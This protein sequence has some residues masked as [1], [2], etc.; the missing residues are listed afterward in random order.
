MMAKRLGIDFFGGTPFLTGLGG[1]LISPGK[2]F[3][4]YSPVAILFFFSIRSFLKKHP[5]PGA[6][7]ICIILS[8]VLFLSKNIYWHGDWAWGPRYMLVITPFLIIPTAH[9][10]DSS[11]W[12]TV[13]FVRGTVYLLFTVSFIIQLAAVSVDYNKYFFH[14]VFDEKVKFTVVSGEGAPSIVEP[15]QETYFELNKSPILAQFRFIQQMAGEIKHYRYKEPSEDSTSEEKVKAEPF[16]HV[17]DYWWLYQYVLDGNRAGI[18]LMIILLSLALYSA[19]RLWTAV[20]SDTGRNG[21]KM[22]NPGSS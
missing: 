10:L 22:V 20:L 17:F 12:L 4:Y 5:G 16:M 9:L 7:F 18:F 15:P 3:F 11:R 13:R 19:A 1:F 14:L 2:G 6:G 8:Y 21:G